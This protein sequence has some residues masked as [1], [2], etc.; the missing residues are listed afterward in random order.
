MPSKKCRILPVYVV[1]RKLR[2]REDPYKKLISKGGTLKNKFATDKIILSVKWRKL[3]SISTKTFRNLKA[4]L[5]KWTSEPLLWHLQSYTSLINTNLCQGRQNHSAFCW[6]LR[7]AEFLIEGGFVCPVLRA[8]IW[9]FSS[10]LTNPRANG[11]TQISLKNEC[12]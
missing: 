2:Q 7:N 5:Q 12:Q 1:F 11:S 8:K 9:I 4:N 6:N 10:A 3:Q